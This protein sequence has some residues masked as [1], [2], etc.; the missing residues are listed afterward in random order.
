MFN[1]RGKRN[2]LPFD[3]CHLKFGY[4]VGLVSGWFVGYVYVIFLHFCLRFLFETNI[5]WGTVERIKDGRNCQ[6]GNTC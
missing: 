6:F 5:K 4:S 1:A 2:D 3:I